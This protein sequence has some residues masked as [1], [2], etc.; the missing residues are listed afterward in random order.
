VELVT[1]YLEDAL[2]RQD[3]RRFESHLEGCPHCTEYLRQMRTVIR[4]TG[5]LKPDD[6]SP[7]VQD[8]FVAL[9][10]RWKSE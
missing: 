1:E 9:F 7:D 5:Q 2:S 6:L 8:E 4:L 3:R 10:R